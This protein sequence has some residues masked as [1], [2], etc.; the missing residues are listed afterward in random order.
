MSL[1]PGQADQ[2][3]N[4]SDKA[5]VT[6]LVA[7][8]ALLIVEVAAFLLLKQRLDRIYSPRT[9]LPPPDKRAESLPKSWWK[10]LPAL[11]KQPAA[12]IIHKNGLDAYMFLRFL[13]M[14]LWIFLA[15]SILS[16]MVIIPVDIV[17]VVSDRVGLDRI[18]WT[19]IE[20]PADDKRFSAHIIVVYLLTFFVFYMIQ[21]EMAHFVHMRHQFLISKSHSRLPQARTVLITAVPSELANERDLRLFASFVPG[22][23]DKVWIYHDTRDLNKLY[24][25][26]QKACKKLEVAQSKILRNATKS[27]R[28][29]E[30]AHK[31]AQKLKGKDEEESSAEEKTLILPP[32]S[33]QLLN[34]LVPQSKRPSHRTGFLGLFGE[35]VDTI[36]WCT[37]EIAELNAQIKE[38]REHVEEG[39]FMGSVFIRCNLQMGAHVLAQC[40]SYHQP[41]A[42]YDRWMETNPADIVWDNLDDGALEM[43]SRYVISW[44]LTF[45]LIIAWGF[46][47]VFIAGLSKIDSLCE[48]VHWLSWVCTAP[49]PVPGIIQGILPPVLLAILFAVL[50]FIL[51]ALAWYECIPRYSLI[52]VS[53]YRRYFFFL[54]VHGFLIA[55][56]SSAITDTI[57]A[58]IDNPTHAVQ[59]LAG[60]L[61]G[62]SILFL[63]YLVTQGLAGAGAALVQLFSLIMYFVRKRFLGRTP[64]QAYEV[65]FLM[66]AADFGTILPRLSLLAT[67]TFAYSVLNPLI[68][69]LAL[70]CFGMFYLAWKFL[71]TQ[72]FDQPDKSETGGMYFPMAVSNLFVGLYIEQICLAC[73]FFLKA[74]QDKTSSIV[75]GILMLVLL[76]ITIGFQIWIQK[77]YDPITKFLPMSLATSKM[78]ERYA[79]Q[80]SLATGLEMGEEIDLFSRQHVCSMRRRMQVLPKKIDATVDTLKAK[81]KATLSPIKNSFDT[82]GRASQDTVPR[83][84]TMTEPTSAVVTGARATKRSFDTTG[85]VSQATAPRSPT[86]TT[87]ATGAQPSPPPPEDLKRVPS[88]VS[89]TSAKSK[90][91]ETEELKLDPPAPAGRDLSNDEDEDEIDPNE[92]A[93]DHPSTY[94]EQPWIWI[95]KDR[96]GLSSVLVSELHNAG[97]DASDVGAVMD[98]KGIVEVSRNP[99][100]K[101]WEGGLDR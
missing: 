57:G 34:E 79:K 42:M 11:I 54:L 22:G 10:W 81:V 3:T 46:P 20:Q 76:G 18:T 63:T 33:T 5:F 78:A 25:R 60:K 86:T 88:T 96:L 82:A 7:N 93:F 8:G 48:K 28:I 6:A 69:P 2:D 100:D 45:G 74:A 32:A 26:R 70:I 39:K 91:A 71:F 21:R 12:D 92:H 55:T 80:R 97:V 83:S 89:S 27:W 90:K 36:E 85:R 98:K 41:M 75:E 19:N 95:P 47:V 44:G 51:Y 49:N 40:V 52:S 84:P 59:T 16:F 43:N 53:V 65:T 73:L 1:V 15:F 94:V 29:K 66:P 23:I 99:P 58:V 35:K 9:F 37:K 31:K 77:S 67:I 4:N 101:E 50:P 30:A 68:N 24:K 56:L 13:K 72:V 14:L 38:R 64:R 62:A 61:P 17:G 87:V